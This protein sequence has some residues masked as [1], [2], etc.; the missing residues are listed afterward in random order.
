LQSKNLLGFSYQ[1]FATLNRYNFTDKV[2]DVV[3][4]S[5]MDMTPVALNLCDLSNTLNY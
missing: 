1:V 2:G 4:S 3:I 5:V